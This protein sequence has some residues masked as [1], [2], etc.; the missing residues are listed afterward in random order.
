MSSFCAALVYVSKSI[1]Y[2]EWLFKNSQL[3][4]FCGGGGFVKDL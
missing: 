4:G 2:N 1:L 3:V